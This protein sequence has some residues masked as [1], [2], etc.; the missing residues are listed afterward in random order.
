MS[1][2]HAHPLG[3]RLRPGSA[4]WSAFASIPQKGRLRTIL[5]LPHS[6]PRPAAFRFFACVPLLPFLPLLLSCLSA[7]RRAQ[8]RAARAAQFTQVTQ[9]EYSHV[10]TAATLT[11][12]T[13]TCAKMLTLTSHYMATNAKHPRYALTWA[14]RA[15]RARQRP[16][17]AGDA[18]HARSTRRLPAEHIPGT[19]RFH[20]GTR[21]LH[22][23]HART[24]AGHAPAK[25]GHES[26]RGSPTPA[27]PRNPLRIV[28]R[29][30]P[31]AISMRGREC[32]HSRPA[33]NGDERISHPVTDRT[34]M[35]L[36]TRRGADAEISF[37]R[38]TEP[39]TRV[40]RVGIFPLCGPY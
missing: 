10:S 33:S 23:G 34:R 29:P 7:C 19:R 18:G 37:R 15:R 22:V 40:R 16:Q 35:Y 27:S 39:A 26:D 36:H 11:S 12:Q 30:H 31:G 8:T 4:R 6:L 2:H 5:G 1:R 25:R 21:R 17:I 14:A 38:F 32:N 3:E 9:A 28:T 20:A 24:H 13:S